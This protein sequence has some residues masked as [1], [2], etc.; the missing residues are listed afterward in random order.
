M[1]TTTRLITFFCY[2]EISLSV[3]IQGVIYKFFYF[4]WRSH[5]TTNLQKKSV[6]DI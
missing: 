5:S 3:E 1:V 4:Q 6:G 2:V